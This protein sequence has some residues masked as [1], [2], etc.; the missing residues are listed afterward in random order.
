MKESVIGFLYSGKGFGRE[1]KMFLQEAKKRN[2]KLIPINIF[3]EVDLEELKNKIKKCE[4]FLNNTAEDLVIEFI[5]TIEEFGKKVVDSSR[6]YYYTE[7]KWMTFLKLKEY[8]IPTP[9]TI[10][11]SGNIKNMEKELKKWGR[12]PVI[13]KR[14]YGT[15]GQYV[16]K[17]ENVQDVENIIEKFWKKG[18]EKY[19]VIAQEFIHSPCYRITVINGKIV[20]TAVK[21]NKSYWKA[22]GVYGNHFKKF[23]IDEK[24]K[25]LV[26]KITKKMKIN[27]CG[28]DLFKKADKWMILEI[29]SE[30]ALDWYPK[31]QRKL[32]GMVLD[33]MKKACK[34]K[35][36]LF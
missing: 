29:N 21:E 30:P 28:I 10:L 1:E 36:I 18:S 24:L 2:I 6:L 19:P 16:E 13:L 11:L 34:N 31:E 8:K 25:K 14:V 4:L 17:A 33:M 20:Q 5:K 22:T 26:E 27:L 12:W 32:V 35:K 9:E 15:I 3:H 23:K 7:D